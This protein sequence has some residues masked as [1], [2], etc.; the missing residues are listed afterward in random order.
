MS[1]NRE[2]RPT[3]PESGESAAVE[4]FTGN[5]ALMLEEKL[6][7]EQ[8]DYAR[9]GVDLPEAPKVASRLSGLERSGGAGR[10]GAAA[11]C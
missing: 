10:V 6:I 7:F 4:T 2:G 11:P 3:R 5:R 8:D 1:M 9:T